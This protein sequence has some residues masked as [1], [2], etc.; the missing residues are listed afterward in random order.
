MCSIPTIRRSRWRV[1]ALL[2]S[3]G[4][5][6]CGIIA[7]GGFCGYRVNVTPSEPLGLWRIIPLDRPVATGDLVFICPP[8]T[9]EM[10]QARER[11]YLRR[12]LCA[13]GYAPLVKTIVAVSGQQVEIGS[14]VK[15]DGRELANSRLVMTDG[16]GRPLVPFSGGIVPAGSVFLHSSFSGS[17]DSRYFGP[18]PASGILGLAQAVLTYAP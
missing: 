8:E 14:S 15:I 18:I 13:D 10:R 9:D 7:I 4:A 1:V 3:T 11:G 5:V 2:I 12:G 16:K 17:W 6:A